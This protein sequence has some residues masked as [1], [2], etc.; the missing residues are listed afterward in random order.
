MLTDMDQPLGVAVGNALEVRE[1]IATLRGDGPADFTELVL[2]SVAHLLAASDL[3]VD[4]DEGRRRAEAAIA[5][6]SALRRYHG[7]ITAQGGN[8]DEAALPRAP[9][10]R[11]VTAVRDGVV[12]RLSAIGVGVAALELGAGRRT[13]EDAIDHAVGVECHAKRGATVGAGETLATVHARDEASADRAGAAV[14]AA[15]QL[16]DEAP[17]QRPIVLETLR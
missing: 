12:T 14:G 16:G 2:V 5:D 8:A 3:G 10:V 11:D 4:E 1:A 9:V 17:E 6:G 15:Y 7:W 13:K